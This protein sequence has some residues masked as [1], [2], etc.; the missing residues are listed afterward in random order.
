MYKIFLRQRLSYIATEINLLPNGLGDT[1]DLSI[2]IYIWYSLC[3]KFDH[4]NH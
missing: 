2:Y 1:Y 3:H 4:K